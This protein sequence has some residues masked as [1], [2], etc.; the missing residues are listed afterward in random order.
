MQPKGG[1]VYVYSF[2]GDVSKEKD[3]SCDGYK[4][5]NK[6]GRKMFTKNKEL[7]WKQTYYLSEA[8]GDAQGSK[9]F[10]GHMLG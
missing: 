7:L 8:K 5:V 10:Q 1:D 6:S 9:L 4:W 2:N 3:W